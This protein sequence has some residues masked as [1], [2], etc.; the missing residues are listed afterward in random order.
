MAE[1]VCPDCAETVLEAA[2]L[3]RFCGH[4]FESNP[5]RSNSPAGGGMRV[6]A[7]VLLMIFGVALMWFGY[8]TENDARQAALLRHGCRSTRSDR[9]EGCLARARSLNPIAEQTA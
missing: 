7:L 8:E 6:A 9:P 3:C 4:R 1:K 5:L 2:A